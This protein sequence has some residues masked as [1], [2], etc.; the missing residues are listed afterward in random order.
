M[1]HDNVVEMMTTSEIFI[2]PSYTEGCPNVVLEAMG[3]RVP[4]IA[5]SVGA[6][7]ELLEDDCGCL[8]PPQDAKKVEEALEF[9]LNDKQMQM[10]YIENAYNKINNDFVIEK[11]FAR[12]ME[13]W[14][15]ILTN[16]ESTNK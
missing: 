7:P 12:Y 6:I 5:S 13:N 11:V 4:V 14:N 10:K 15:G 9:L 1:P 2:L 16:N 8:I 3:Y